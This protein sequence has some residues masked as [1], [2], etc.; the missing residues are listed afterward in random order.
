MQMTPI[1]TAL[2]ASMVNT[3]ADLQ[4]IIYIAS[5]GGGL[6]MLWMLYLVFLRSDATQGEYMQFW[7]ATLLVLV[8]VTILMCML[9]WSMRYDYNQQRDNLT[10]LT[11]CI[12]NASWKAV[13]QK[14]FDVTNMNTE[15]NWAITFMVGGLLLIGAMLWVMMTTSKALAALNQE[16]EGY[17]M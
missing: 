11:N 3:Y 12:T 7:A 9:V 8:V 4:V 1:M 10:T 17:V 5:I 13:P 6:C 14:A 2:L 16:R 15:H